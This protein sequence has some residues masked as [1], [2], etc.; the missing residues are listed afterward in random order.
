MAILIG[1]GRILGGR[2]REEDG[3]SSVLDWENGLREVRE[4][5]QVTVGRLLAEQKWAKSAGL[6]AMI[7]LLQH[8]ERTC[9]AAARTTAASV[10]LKNG[11][12]FLSLSLSLSD[13]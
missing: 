5:M 1:E 11:E 8:A 10:S 9:E 7:E 13:F 6:G 4:K 3:S 12:N 2:V